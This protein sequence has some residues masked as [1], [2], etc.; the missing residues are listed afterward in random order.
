[1]SKQTLYNTNFLVKIKYCPNEIK[2]LPN[3]FSNCRSRDKGRPLCVEWRRW[4]VGEC[5]LTGLT[6]LCI[7]VQ[8]LTVRWIWL[9]KSLHNITDIHL[10]RLS[11]SIFKS[12]IIERK[13]VNYVLYFTTLNMVNNEYLETNIIVKH[14][15]PSFCYEIK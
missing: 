3:C 1:M 12:K 14:L 15:E 10:N 6:L 5:S 2:M 8:W 9:F 13:I 7:E 4:L 11:G